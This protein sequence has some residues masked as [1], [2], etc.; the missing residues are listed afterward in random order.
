MTM[1]IACSLTIELDDL[2]QLNPT[3]VLCLQQVMSLV[4]HQVTNLRLQLH[5]KKN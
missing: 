4:P 2:L 1:S 5:Q 3:R